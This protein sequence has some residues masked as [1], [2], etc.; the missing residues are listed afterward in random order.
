MAWTVVHSPRMC[1]RPLAEVTGGKLEHTLKPPL[2]S[3]VP[4][5]QRQG[6][7]MFSSNGESTKTIFDAS[8]DYLYPSRSGKKRRINWG[9]A[10]VQ[11]G[12]A[13]TLPREITFNAAARLLQQYPIEEL[14][15]LRSNVL[16]SRHNF[17]IGSGRAVPM[18]LSTGVAKQSEA[19]VTFNLPDLATRFGVSVGAGTPPK[20]VKVGTYMKLTDLP[21]K[22]YNITHYGTN[23]DPRM[24]QDAC[25]ADPKCKAWT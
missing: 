6:G 12:S 25:I 19:M 2:K 15:E 21:G 7:K 3:S 16:F 20:G 18:G 22:Y 14:K 23:A 24:C 13:Q 17:T 10:K 9:W 11:P 8:K 1:T 5:K 4:F